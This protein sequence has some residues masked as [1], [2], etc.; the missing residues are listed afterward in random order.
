M[1]FRKLRLITNRFCVISSDDKNTGDTFRHCRSKGLNHNADDK[2]KGVTILKAF[3]SSFFIFPLLSF[4]ISHGRPLEKSIPAAKAPSASND[5]SAKKMEATTKSATAP[6]AV[7]LKIQ[8]EGL[9]S[10]DGQVGLTLFDKKD[11]A[12]FPTRPQK[13]L[14]NKLYP[15]NGKS[16]LEIQLDGLAE[17]E[18]AAFA[19][20][21]EDMNG[22]LNANFMHIPTEG[23]GCTQGAKNKFGPPKYEDAKFEFKTASTESSSIKIKIDY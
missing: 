17:G 13:A 10:G 12:D 19:Y 1:N 22:K 5:V 23:Y 2:K 15:L 14:V 6:K 21:D 7:V 9:K 16:A 3:G 18:Y 4:H 8:V 11:A 20:H